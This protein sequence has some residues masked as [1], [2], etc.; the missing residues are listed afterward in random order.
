MVKSKV[1]DKN[2]KKNT[3]VIFIAIAIL[4]VYCRNNRV[5]FNGRFQGEGFR[6]HRN[7]FLSAMDFF[8][9]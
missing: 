6:V 7:S 3:L 2:M 8:G 9:C 4:R 1:K 5:E